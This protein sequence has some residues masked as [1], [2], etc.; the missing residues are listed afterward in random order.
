MIQFQNKTVTIFQSAL[1]HTTS[2]VVQSEDAILL[3]DPTWLPHEVSEI[4]AFVRD[5]RK[6]RPLYLIFTHSDWDHI[7]GYSAFPDATVIASQSLEEHPDKESILN[8]IQAFDQKYYIVRDYKIEFPRVDIVVRVDGQMVQI[9]ATKLTFYTA[10]G[11]TKDGIF[12]VVEPYGIWIAG[13]YLSDLEFPYIYDSSVSYEETMHKS[14][15]IMQEHS[16]ELLIPGHGNVTADGE[17]M[18]ARCDQSL[19]YIHAMRERIQ[20]QDWAACA[21]L[22]DSCPFPGGMK[23]FHEDNR[24]LMMKELG[25]IEEK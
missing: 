12:T 22:I 3:F 18:A 11:H 16:I 2:T 25:V 1:Y 8:Q 6:G 7:L 13:D 9:G 19:A 24:V 10:P 17:Q 20:Q 4:Q 23:S 15:R 5:G 14:R 21:R